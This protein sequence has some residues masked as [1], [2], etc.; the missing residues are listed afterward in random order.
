MDQALV[1]GRPARD[2]AWW[3][4]FAESCDD[5]H[6]AAAVRHLLEHDPDVLLAVDDVDTSLI[7]T[8]LSMPVEDRMRYAVGTAMDLERCR[9]AGV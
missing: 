4:T 1:Q 9:L 2:L 7:D 3:R 5:P 8:W 6:F